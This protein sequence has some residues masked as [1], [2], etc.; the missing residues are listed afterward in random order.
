MELSANDPRLDTS[1]SISSIIDS[2]KQILVKVDC[3]V[4]RFCVKGLLRSGRTA[5]DG[6]LVEPVRQREEMDKKRL[7][8]R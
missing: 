4:L 1:E 3:L 2:N 7:Y 8:A 5:Y 6:I